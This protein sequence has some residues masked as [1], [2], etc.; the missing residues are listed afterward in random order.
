[1]PENL[2][3]VGATDGLEPTDGLDISDTATPEETA[4]IA[5]AVDA[6]LSA[7]ALAVAAAT[8]DDES[9]TWDGD[10]WRFR[11][12]MEALG[13]RAGRVPGGAPREPWRAAGR[14]DRF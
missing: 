9:E 5:A 3:G 7:E 2:D 14:T 6:Y 4:A 1:M 12:R 13:G 11:G 8:G 10:R